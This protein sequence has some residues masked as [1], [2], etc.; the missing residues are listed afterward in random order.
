MAKVRS[1]KSGIKIRQ[2]VVIII[3]PLERGHFRTGRAPLKDKGYNPLFPPTGSLFELQ[4]KEGMLWGNYC[5]S[6]SVCSF[7]SAT[8]V[9]STVPLFVSLLGFL[10]VTD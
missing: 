9:A 7:N 4:R 8:H 1:K 6:R 5:H 2:K 10:W 3:N